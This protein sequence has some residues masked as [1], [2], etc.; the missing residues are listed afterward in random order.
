[1]DARV[2]GTDVAASLVA[3]ELSVGTDTGWRAG[4]WTS[5]TVADGMATLSYPLAGGNR[6]CS[7]VVDTTAPPTET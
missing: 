2:Y 5:Y 1:M 3:T 6:N 7:L 4:A